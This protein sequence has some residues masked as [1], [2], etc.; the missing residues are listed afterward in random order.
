ML[1]KI[2]ASFAV[3]GSAASI[4]GLGT[5]ATFTASTTADGALH[6]G[7]V[8]IGLGGVGGANRLTVGASG[9]LPGDTLQRV[10]DLNNTSGAGSDNLGAISLTTTATPTSL[11]DSDAVNGLQMKVEKCPTAWVEAGTAPAYTYS[12][13][14][15]VTTVLAQRAVIGSNLDLGTVAAL[16][17]GGSDHLRVTLSL[18]TTAPNT[19]Q[20]LASSI[21]YTFNAVQRASGA[22]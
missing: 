9:L 22:K 13:S 6:T 7:A 18:P 11:L 21:D 15:A 3:L 16:T 5:F 17:T 4:A 8:S 12:C 14:G 2:L 10:V 20:S 1:T 19:M